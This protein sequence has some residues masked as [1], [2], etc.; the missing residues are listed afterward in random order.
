[1]LNSY[2]WYCEHEAVA[3][4]VAAARAWSDWNDY[5]TSWPKQPRASVPRGTVPLND[6]IRQSAARRIA[7]IRWDL[8]NAGPFYPREKVREALSH[9]KIEL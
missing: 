9:W 3:D 2:D 4:A 8:E 1:S 5:P 6:D 7:R